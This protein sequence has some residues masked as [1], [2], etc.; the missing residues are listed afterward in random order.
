MRSSLFVSGYTANAIAPHG[1][2]DAGIHFLQESFSTENMP[3][4]V[5]EVLA[6]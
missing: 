1:V 6:A 4:E 2:L 3:L 5:S